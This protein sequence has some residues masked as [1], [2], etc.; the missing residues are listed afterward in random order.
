MRLSSI[1]IAW[2][3]IS[4]RVV[5]W[6]AGDRS[7]VLVSPSTLNTVMVISAASFGRAVNH[8]A[9]AQ[10]SITRLAWQL[11]AASSST[12]LKL[13]YT[14]RVLLRPVAA[15]AA[16]AASALLNSSIKAATL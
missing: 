12:S 14:N 13:S 7:S 15:S 11:L 5:A 16:I 9:F 4:G 1:A 2:S 3:G 6:V 8:S 10:L